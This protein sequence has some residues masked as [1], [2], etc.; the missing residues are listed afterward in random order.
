MNENEYMDYL[1]S[2]KEEVNAIDY[3]GPVVHGNPIDEE[4]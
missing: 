2:L 4:Q 3:K 1:V